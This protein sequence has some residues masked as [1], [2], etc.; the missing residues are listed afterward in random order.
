MEESGGGGDC[1]RDEAEEVAE[2][3][4]TEEERH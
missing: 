3:T 4:A 1:I 2:G